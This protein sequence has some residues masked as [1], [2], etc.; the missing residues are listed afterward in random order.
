M[1]ATNGNSDKFSKLPELVKPRHYDITLKPD[2]TNFTFEGH[3]TIKLEV[4]KPTNFLKFHSSEIV[5]SEASAKTS[6]GAE[7]SNLP[8]EYDSKWMTVTLRLPEEVAKGDVTLTLKFTGVL[9]D[10]MH[11]FY[12]SSYKAADGTQ[13]YLASTQFE[14]T[15][16]R[17][18]FPCWDEP[19]YKAT[20]DV[21]LVVDEH[22]TALSNMGV[23]SEN[24]GDGKKTVKYG[25]TPIMSTYLVAFVVGEFDYVE[26]QTKGG[27]AM[28]VYSVPGK[29]EQ[30]E[31]ALELATRAIEWYNEWFGIDYPLPKCDLIAIPDFSMGIYLFL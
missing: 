28:R 12:R 27:V 22:L 25:T 15:Y 21:T 16:A 13:R 18:S 29:K 1:S 10:K 6:E 23:V 8:I 2:L 5:I 3:E 14:S 30:G 9:N 7:W 19:L 31:F 26:S 20:F 24:V 11:G 17:L 4:V